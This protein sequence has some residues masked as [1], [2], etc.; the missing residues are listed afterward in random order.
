M[1]LEE[2]KELLIIDKHNLDIAVERQSTLCNQVGEQMVEA[3][4]MRDL[5]KEDLACVDAKIADK[6]RKI[7]SEEG[8]KITEAKIAQRTSTDLKHIEAM[9]EYLNCKKKAAMWKILR[10]DFTGRAFMVSQMCGLYD[11]EYFSK[12]HVDTSS[13][14]ER[15][16]SRVRENA[17]EEKHLQRKRM[18]RE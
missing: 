10:E 8:S 13:K 9:K 18:V 2:A 11:S 14:T 4:S 5:K 16:R 7:A 3:E 17:I 1:T 15:S 12:A 6:L